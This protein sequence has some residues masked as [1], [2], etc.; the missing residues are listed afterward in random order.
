M[1][2]CGISFNICYAKENYPWSDYLNQTGKTLSNSTKIENV[3]GCFLD[4]KILVLDLYKTFPTDGN[5]IVEK[6]DRKL[7]SKFFSDEL[8]KLLVSDYKCRKKTGGVCKIDFNILSN[9]Q[10]DFGSFKILQ[11][12]NNVVTV[13]FNTPTH[14]EFVDFY[15]ESKGKCKVIKDIKY[16]DSNLLN[17]LTN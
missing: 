6:S 10:D 1:V 15:M 9:S 4:S 17:I 2:A 11:A 7:I 16:N 3:H 13:K 12:T 14:G 8:T 5:K